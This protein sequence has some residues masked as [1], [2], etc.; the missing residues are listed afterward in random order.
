MSGYLLHHQAM[1]LISADTEEDEDHNDVDD[2]NDDVAAVVGT[3]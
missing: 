1:V 3:E 2:S